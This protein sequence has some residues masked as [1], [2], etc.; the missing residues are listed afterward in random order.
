MAKS[1]TASFRFNRFPSHDNRDGAVNAKMALTALMVPSPISLS[2]V[3]LPIGTAIM[4]PAFCRTLDRRRAFFCF[5]CFPPALHS[6]QYFHRVTSM[7]RLSAQPPAR[8]KQRSR[9][10]QIFGR[11]LRQNFAVR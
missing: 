9:S 6:S 8:E 7:I 11:I 5:M 2:V 10:R 3:A 4:P 1:T